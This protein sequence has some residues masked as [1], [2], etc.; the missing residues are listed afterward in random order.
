MKRW[1]A[2]AV[3]GIMLFVPAGVMADPAVDSLREQGILQGD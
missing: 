2:G 3:A 1:M